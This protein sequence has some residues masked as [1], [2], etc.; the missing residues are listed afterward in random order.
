MQLNDKT[1]ISSGTCTD[2]AGDGPEVHGYISGLHP[3][4]RMADPEEIA[5]AALFLLSN[6]ASFVTGSAM[7]ADG[8]ISIRL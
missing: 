4:G 1:I 8:G 2:M 6:R 5:E 7:T 3:P